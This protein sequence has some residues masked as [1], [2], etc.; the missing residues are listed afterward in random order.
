MKDL[1]KGNITKLIVSFALP[2]LFGNIFQLFYNLADTRIVGQFL[3]DNALAAI[4]A[5][6]SLNWVIIGF[7]NGL[8]N[9]FAIVGARFFG[10]KDHNRVRRA[11]AHA[12]TLGMATAIIFTAFSLAFIDPILKHMNTPAEIM[13]QAKGYIYIILAGMTVT[14]LYNV[15][16]GMLGA[17]G[18]TVSPLIFLII[19]TFVNILLDLLF[20]LVLKTGVKGAAYATIISQVLSVILCVIFIFKKHKILIPRLKDFKFNIPLAGDMYAAGASMG[21]MI[22]LVGIGTVVIQGAI[23][24]F[25]TQIIVAHTT[26]RKIS[27]MFMLPIS[28]FG[29]ASATFSSQNYGAGKIDRVRKGLLQT[30]LITWVWSVIVILITWIGTPF[31]VKLIT[32]ITD[33][34][35]VKIVVKYMKINTAFYFIL[36]IVIMFRNA[37]QGVGDKIT[38][39]VSSIIE[40]VGKCLMAMF[41]APRVG[42]FGIII[43]E[44]IVWIGMALC[45]AVGFLSNKTLGIKSR[46]KLLAD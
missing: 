40:L 21:L 4:G 28:V 9:G 45:L 31:L 43:N 42:Y 13:P 37:L 38:P 22:S 1:T 32:G 27:E 33:T 35:T 25:G 11:F 44:P 18:D 39:I 16:A 24:N 12:I 19:S 3:G 23:N 2:L 34:E 14:M 7:L 46:K 30:T 36:D 26:A 29:M 17:I 5:T 20:V 10:A 41:L 15:C 8:A 6:S